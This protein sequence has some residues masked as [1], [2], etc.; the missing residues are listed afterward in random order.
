[1]CGG[2]C[3]PMAGWVCCP[4]NI[5]CSPDVLSCPEHP[6]KME[7]MKLTALTSK[8]DCPGVIC[9]SGCCAKP[10]WVCCPDGVYCASV[11][12]FCPPTGKKI[13]KLIELATKK[14]GVKCDGPMCPGGCCPHEGY[15]CCPDGKYCASSLEKCPSLKN[16]LASFSHLAPR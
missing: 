2:K 16:P 13:H 5:Y 14:T 7:L 3:C 9:P 10:G 15:V 6:K 1:M 11:V 12:E 8:Q 4:D